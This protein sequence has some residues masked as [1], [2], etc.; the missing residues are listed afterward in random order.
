MEDD[1][2]MRWKALGLVLKLALI[3]PMSTE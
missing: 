3:F 2:A 1:M